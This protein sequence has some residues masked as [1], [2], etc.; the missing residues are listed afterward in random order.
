MSAQHPVHEVAQHLPLTVACVQNPVQDSVSVSAQDTATV[1]SQDTV[2][3]SAQDAVPELPTLLSEQHPVSLR[4]VPPTFAPVAVSQASDGSTIYIKQPSLGVK[5]IS[6]GLAAC[7][8]DMV[9]FPLDTAKVRLQV[10]D[11]SYSMAVIMKVV[12]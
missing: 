4:P 12:G 8:A 2:E 6:A 9:T 1:A 7:W 3:V 11:L 10:S 5:F